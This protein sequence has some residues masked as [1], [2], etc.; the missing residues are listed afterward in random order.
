[1]QFRESVTEWR[2]EAGELVLTT[3][4]VGVTTGKVVTSEGGDK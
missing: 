1:M 2:D 3:R 4:S